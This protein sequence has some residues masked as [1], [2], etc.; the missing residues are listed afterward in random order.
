MNRQA[1]SFVD[2]PPSALNHHRRHI[3]IHDPTAAAP[4]T[5]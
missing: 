4:K 3:K 1:N 5:P 2:L